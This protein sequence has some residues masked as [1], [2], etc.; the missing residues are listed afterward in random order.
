MAMHLVIAPFEFL[1]R[2]RH[3]ILKLRIYL[4]SQPVC[5]SESLADIN[6]LRSICISRLPN[7][8]VRVG[9]RR[10]LAVETISGQL[11]EG[12]PITHKL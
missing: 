6:F 10:H 5:I 1:L 2:G 8:D 4:E 7:G 9:L 12:R 3:E 11:Y